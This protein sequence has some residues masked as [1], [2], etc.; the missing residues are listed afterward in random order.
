MF[1]QPHKIVSVSEDMVKGVQRFG[2]FSRINILIS[3]RRLNYNS[4]TF[5]KSL[6]MRQLK[7]NTST[8][9]TSQTYFSLK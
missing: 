4:R 6:S 7:N 1:Y 3:E 9:G 8:I 5:N 2:E